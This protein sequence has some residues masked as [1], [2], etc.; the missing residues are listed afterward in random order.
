MI[1]I[2]DI[3]FSLCG[4]ILLS[5]LGLVIYIITLFDTGN[6]LFKQRR[7]GK[8]K[9]P[10]TLYK[11]R[12]LHTDAASLPTHLAGQSKVSKFGKFLRKSKFDELPQL[13]NVLVGEMSIVG[14]R[15]NLLNQ[16]TLI[17]ERE[18]HGI[19]NHLP[20]ITGLAQ[21]NKIDMSTPTRLAQVDAEMLQKLTVRD[22]FKY[23]LATATGKGHGDRVMG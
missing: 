13:L 8:N 10:F 19:Y 23:I 14:P 20:G 9:V 5:P 22:Y 15:P 18:K 7:M 21:I 1:R 4:I 17:N 11:F 16:P 6:P 3:T 2:L 12:T